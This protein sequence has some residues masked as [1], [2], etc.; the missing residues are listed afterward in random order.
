MFLLLVIATTIYLITGDY[1]DRFFGGYNC[2]GVGHYIV[3]G[4]SN[5]IDPLKKLSQLRLPEAL[6]ACSNLTPKEIKQIEIDMQIMAPKGYRVLGID[7]IT[8]SGNNIPSTNKN[9][10]LN[11]WDL[12]RRG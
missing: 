6:I 1:G 4:S 7:V 5:A 11:L 2:L 12:F 3:S 9:F 8:F 10:L